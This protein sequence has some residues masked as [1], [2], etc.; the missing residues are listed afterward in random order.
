VKRP[1][2][3]TDGRLLSRY[4][5]S[6]DDAAFE[7]LYERT[8][9]RLNHM[10]R[11]MG[12]PEDQ[13]EDLVQDVFLGVLMDATRYDA[14]RSFSAWAGGIAW[15]R[16]LSSRRRFL[17]RLLPSGTL[18]A[19][20]VAP[21]PDQL[22]TAEVHAAI[23]AGLERLAARD[24]EILELYYV[25]RLRTS[26]IARRL[27]RNTSTVRSRIARALARLRDV[28]PLEITPSALLFIRFGRYP[29]M[30][31]APATTARWRPAGVRP[32]ALRFALSGVGLSVA[33]VVLS[34]VGSSS[35]APAEP[36][37]SAVTSARDRTAG[38]SAPRIEALRTALP[39]PVEATTPAP[40][41]PSTPELGAT[42]RLRFVDR[43]T[44][45]PVPNFAF[46]LQPWGADEAPAMTELV[47]GFRGFTTD[48]RGEAV[49]RDVAP[50]PL[51]LRYNAA[52]GSPVY[53]VVDVG[54]TEL[55]IE[56]DPTAVVDGH[57]F[58]DLGRPVA[59]AEVWTDEIT[60]ASFLCPYLVGQTDA[61]GYYR[62]AYA[63]GMPKKLWARVP[64]R[65]CSQARVVTLNVTTA[66][67]IDLVLEPATASIEGR[68]TDEGA[69]VRN[70]VV[71]LITKGETGIRSLVHQVAADDEGRF[72]FET[73]PAHPGTLI[74]LGPD[75][76]TAMT[77]VE[78]SENPG[79]SCV[80]ELVAGA[81][82]VGSSAPEG[83]V[84]A[85]LPLAETG[86]RWELARVVTGAKGGR[87][88]LSSVPPGSVEL[89]ML[90][91][92]NGRVLARS[93]VEL[94]AGQALDWNPVADPS[95]VPEQAY[96][97]R[98]Y[99]R[100]LRDCSDAVPQPH[101]FDHQTDH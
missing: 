7:Q 18:E 71:T 44:G 25:E 83:A 53:P 30:P 27:D 90:D 80:L 99:V 48:D 19:E 31:T 45:A 79:S 34:Q 43:R 85:A 35:F 42:V 33:A 73:L 95:G 51:R 96:R 74:A 10:A 16:I 66:S 81:S 15:Y 61:R 100:W 47:R 40:T 52:M 76:S 54:E 94:T 86:S 75:G 88:V 17:Q 101:F 13:L 11:R 62:V 5:E 65:S 20:R 72:R 89:L 38:P 87:F 59:G 37:A 63:S 14:R 12:V 26:E 93:T 84:L 68:V 39:L 1:G 9:P 78:L 92:L 49:L 55:E 50:V 23:R 60:D 28:L 58:D 32:L 91:P 57:V 22:E 21:P 97:L 46:A 29:S 36:E 82:V 56:L 8:A 6:G 41:M 77:G 98:R 64:G 3:L 24:R 69:P 67:A 2:F 4:I 70:A